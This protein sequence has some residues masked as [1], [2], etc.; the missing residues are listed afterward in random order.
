[1]YDSRPVP[2]PSRVGILRRGILIDG[3]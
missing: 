2:D 1:V 3:C